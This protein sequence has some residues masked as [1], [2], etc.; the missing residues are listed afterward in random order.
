MTVKDQ[1]IRDRFLTD[2]ERNAL[3]EAGAGTGKTTLV[4]DRL[5][6]LVSGRRCLDA[7]GRGPHGTPCEPVPL[8]ELVAITFT[9]LAAAELRDRLRERLAEERARAGDPDLVALLDRALQDL[10][11]AAITT[12]HGFSTRVLRRHALAA[13]LD[14][15]F[16]VL[17]AVATRRL[18]REVF[19][20][21]FEELTHQPAVRR[22]LAHGVTYEK[23][24]RR[25]RELLD[26]GPAV[27]DAHRTDRGP[28]LPAV[29]R[30]VFDELDEWIAEREG[31]R[32]MGLDLPDNKYGFALDDAEVLLR[33][34]PVWR[35]PS[36]DRDADRAAWTALELELMLPRWKKPNRGHA[37]PAK[38]AKAVASAGG[39]GKDE[40]PARTAA[41]ADG[42]AELR[43]AVARE[44]L[45]DLEPILLGFRE[46][47]V[48]E[49]RRRSAL[50]FD[51]LLAVAED[52]VRR[53]PAVRRDLI[54][55][56]RCLFVDEFQDTD[57]L[58]AR[59]VYLLAGDEATTGETDWTRV[60]PA[61][62]RLVLVGDPKQSIYR[63]RGADVEVFRAAADRL[64]AADPDARYVIT[65]NFRTD[66]PL[67]HW[68]GARFEA[69]PAR[70]VAPA[71]GAYQADFQGLTPFHEDRGAARPV[72]VLRQ[73]DAERRLG[74]GG[75]T[76]AEARAV[77]QLLAATFRDADGRP[78]AAR[79]VDDGPD[80]DLGG[81]AVVARKAKVLAAY[82]AALAAE[83]LPY[84]AEGGGKLLEAEEALTALTVLRAVCEPGRVTAVVGAL[85]SVW[86]AVSDDALLAHG[87]V[88]GGLDPLAAAPG[89]PGD[90]AV[91]AGLVRL[92]S[93]ARRA[94][95]EPEAVLAEVLRDP[96]LLL[97]L[98]LRPA[99]LQAPMNLLLLE[100]RLR[101]QLAGDGLGAVV[102]L[103]SDLARRG[104]DEKGARLE[105]PGAVRLLTV[106]GAKGLEFPL[107]VLAGLPGKSGGDTDRPPAIDADGRLVWSLGSGL[108]TGAF[109]DHKAWSDL[110]ATAEELRLFYVA[111]TR[112]KHHLVLPLFPAQERTGVDGLKKL[113]RAGFGRLLGPDLLG[114]EL[115]EPP[116]PKKGEDPVPPDPLTLGIL[117]REGLVELAPASP[118]PATWP[119]PPG[120]WDHLAGALGPGGAPAT[121]PVTLAAD[122]AARA[123]QRARTLA[124]SRLLDAGEDPGAVTGSPTPSAAGGPGAADPSEGTQ[125]T[126][127]PSGTDGATA[128]RLGTLTHLCLELGL[129]AA[130]ARARA[131]AEGLDPDQVT[132]VAD[133]VA[134]ADD[135]PCAE[136]ARTAARVLDE[137][138]LLWRLVP[139]A[140]TGGDRLLRGFIDRLLCFDDGSVE[141]IDFKTDRVADAAGLAERADHHAV[142]L[143][144]YGLAL[145][146]AG[147][148][149]RALTLA[150]LASGDEVQVPFDEPLRERVRQLVR[151]DGPTGGPAGQPVDRDPAR[152]GG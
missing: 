72:L 112:A 149:V 52:L 85:R 27:D 107:V 62:G 145:E 80:L 25:A 119:L 36:G 34:H 58:Q 106:H 40:F 32:A 130:G 118:P 65:T 121:A 127:G 31:W 113:C 78:R 73:P 133:C 87:R 129:D 117:G 2:L 55:G 41:F 99:G 57:P 84:V 81:V 108:E 38:W 114:A 21:W 110:R 37:A 69:G 46:H 7:Q 152:S 71:E 66:G 137:P 35:A 19:D 123:P 147:F 124:P 95:S 111:M 98:A 20:D 120:G 63:F 126:D 61:P 16:E 143:G 68:V 43:E 23:L 139:D 115:P 96:E 4:V 93:W 135:L 109:T 132:F 138:H 59:L 42:I 76:A 144:L 12:I 103:Y 102:R 45:A 28:G 90:P 104:G 60:P 67:V 92:G 75:A 140:G 26:L 49:K 3:V 51:D 33:A 89:D 88:G 142:Q 50:D 30:R 56:T 14:P 74:T 148:P 24:E 97:L 128:R 94:G 9:E 77:A 70:M 141:V 22:A 44:V 10:P 13:G 83:G 151:T 18:V 5:V 6:A 136:R 150:F 100:T 54:R 53:N 48:A 39:P 15:A 122:L 91:V 8:T 79:L 131:T 101:A 11:G 82:A 146:Q 1:A 86:C 105:L 47:Y 134:R 116:K 64:C 17:D 29:T 125:G